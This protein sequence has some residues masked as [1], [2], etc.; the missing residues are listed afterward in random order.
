METE[1]ESQMAEALADATRLKILKAL[2]D[3]GPDNTTLTL[4]ALAWTLQGRLSTIQHHLA[5]L[6]HMGLVI[7]ERSKTM[8]Y[9][10]HPQRAEA[11]RAALAAL[12]ALAAED[13]A[14][15]P[16]PAEG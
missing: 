16:E 10:L 4:G 8:A 12:Q 14:A 3:L 15:P 11:T 2:A 5:K 13:R 1:R 9:S 7:A 6:R